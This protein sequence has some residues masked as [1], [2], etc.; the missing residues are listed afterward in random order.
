VKISLL[1]PA[2]AMHR[3][4]GSF[5][6][7]LH[8]APLT[9]TTLAA[10]IPDDLEAEVEIYDETA[11]VIPKDL[12]ADIIG[13]TAITGTSERA[14]CWA[15]YYRH[16]GATVVLGGV[17]PTLMPKEAAQHADTVMVGFTEQT[18]PRMLRDFKSGV[19]KKCYY[20]NSDFSIAG[21]PPPRRDL[22]KRKRYVTLN[23][24]EAIRGCHLPCIFCAY[25]A[26]FGRN[27]YKRPVRE[28]IEEI[29]MLKGKEVLFPDINLIADHEYARELFREMVPL[30]KWWF[31]LTTSDVT[32]DKELFNLIVQSGCR[33]LLIGFESITQNTQKFVKKG[34]NNVSNYDELI[35]KL[36]DAGIAINGCFAFGGDD[37]DASVF[38]RT[39]E[40][41]IR[42][43]IDLPR[44]SILTPFPGTQLYREFEQQGRIIERDWAMYDVEH[45]VFRPKQMTQEDLEEGIDRAWKETY[46]IVNIVKRLATFG[47]P[48]FATI[49]ANFFG[50]RTYARK[51]GRFGRSVMTDNSDIE[52]KEG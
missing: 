14:Y 1:A 11:G 19:L 34:I 36:H 2:G 5:K 26:A 10:L 50:Y 15:D 41:V 39:T 44:Y 8:Y 6:K 45:C 42:L 49:P 31:G 7:P 21:R 12:N 28:V 9:L 40:E 16:R 38:E 30:K 4:S 52:T 24:V 23:S 20:Q 22:L 17:H 13:I 29:E 27:I 18:W 47:T 43:K 32:K 3:Y 35:N 51:F 46:S 25:P 37:E 48:H 33:G